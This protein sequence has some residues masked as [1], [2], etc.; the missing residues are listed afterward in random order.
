GNR[1]GIPAEVRD[2]INRANIDDERAKLTEQKQ[3]LREGGVTDDE[4]RELKKIDAKLASLTAIE[5]TL[6]RGDRQLLV[7]DSSGERLKAAV[8]VGNVDT[9]KHVAVFT[10]GLTSTVDGSLKGYDDDMQKLVAKSKEQLK[11]AGEDPSVAAVTWIGYE[12]PQ[13]SGELLDLAG[14]ERDSVVSSQSAR[15]GGEKLNS[16][17][18]GIN[19]SRGSDPHLTAIGHSYGSTT[20][21]YALQKGGHGVDDA[22]VFGSPG[23]GTDNVKDL[24]VPEGHT[25]RMEAAW[26]PVAD[27]SRFG[28]DPSHM[29]GFT[30][31]STE[32][33]KVGGEVT[34][35]TKYL[36]DDS[37]SQHN[38]AAVIAGHPEKTVQGNSEGVGD[39][40]S[41]YLDPVFKTGTQIY[42]TGA[43][44]LS[45]SVDVG[46]DI[47]SKVFGEDTVSTVKEGVKDVGSEVEST[48]EDLGS[49]AIDKAKDLFS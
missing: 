36:T 18:A 4:Q 28:K 2:Q 5:E 8:A 12:A 26:D 22:I 17:L 9:A 44:V 34:G 27:F 31:L 48:V 30:D 42:D 35:H 41:P 25:Y 19:E 47:A 1:D 14:S 37:T 45:K 24:H 20:T 33:S 49:A 6:A 15:I 40:V 32:K 43:D 3:Q 46:S 23:V 7:L 13:V 16:F 38:L 21:G 29:D 39:M 11:L 10:P